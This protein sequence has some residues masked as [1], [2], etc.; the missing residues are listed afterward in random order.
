MTAKL[1]WLDLALLAVLALLGWQLRQEWVRMHA[2]Q[3]S[4]AKSSVPPAPVAA[5]PPLSHVEPLTASTYADVATKNLFSVDR[6]AN[7][8]IE[9]PKPVAEKPP[10]PFPVA[11]GVMLWE[12]VPPTVVFSER[13]NGPQKGYHPGDKVGPWTLESVD[14]RYV[15]LT[16]EGKKFKKRIDELL[17]RTPVVVAEAPPV[18]AKAQPNTPAPAP[19]VLSP[20]SQSGPGAPM[21]GGFF[22]CSPGDSSA[23]GAVVNGLKKVVGQTPFGS[24]CHWEQAK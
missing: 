18:Q 19:Q 2:R 1:R 4:L 20:G 9:P 3:Q 17:D 16:W 15:D 21:G 12:G 7:V 22:A 13:A 24:S 5:L 23:D 14:D 11:H 8:I 10:P 6:N